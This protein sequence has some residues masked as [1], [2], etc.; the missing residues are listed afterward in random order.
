MNT[1]TLN[2][3]DKAL[4]VQ[5]RLNAQFVYNTAKADTLLHCAELILKD[6]F[7]FEFAHSCLSEVDYCFLHMLTSVASKKEVSRQ[8]NPE[9]ITY[10]Q[11]IRVLQTAIITL[12]SVHT[13]FEADPEK[14]DPHKDQLSQLPR[15]DLKTSIERRS[16]DALPVIMLCIFNSPQYEK[17][18][19]SD[20]WRQ[21]MLNHCLT[22]M[23]LTHTLL[24]KRGL[25]DRE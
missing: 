9:R 16:F 21:D 22:F 8:R 24:L 12:H 2:R 14:Y 25:G 18:C 4:K 1:P 17:E 11:F 23:S 7:D 3:L 20:T 5:K 13:Q 6:D 10:P 19:Q 15:K